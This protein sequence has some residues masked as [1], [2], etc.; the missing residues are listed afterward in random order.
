MRITFVLFLRPHRFGG[1]NLAKIFDAG[2]LSRE[3]TVPQKLRHGDSREQAN[4]AHNDHNLNEREAFAFR[5][6]VE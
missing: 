5:T 6:T 4:D 3:L 2:V 1:G